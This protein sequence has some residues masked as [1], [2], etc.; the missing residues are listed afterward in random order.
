MSKLTV[1]ISGVQK[2]HERFE[3]N[4]GTYRLDFE[5]FLVSIHSS[6]NSNIWTNFSAAKAVIGHISLLTQ[7]YIAQTC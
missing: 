1:N 5:I 2:S 3:Q 6:D 4:E 7:V